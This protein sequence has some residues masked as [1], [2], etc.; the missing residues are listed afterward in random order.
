MRNAEVQRGL[1]RAGFVPL[2]F[3]QP[4]VIPDQNSITLIWDALAGQTYQV[5]Y[6]PD[7]TTWFSS[8]TGQ[9]VPNGATASWTDIGP[10]GTLAPP[11]N[12]SQRF[13][14]VFQL[15]GQ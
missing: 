3:Q 9:I 7:L 8:P 2:P 13:Y 10:P 1:Q 6:S 4:N 12:V 15:G 11:F 5:E 14:R